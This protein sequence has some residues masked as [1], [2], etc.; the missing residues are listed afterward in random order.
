[1]RCL[2]LST[3]LAFALPLGSS[4]TAADPQS[5]PENLLP[6][7]TATGEIPGWMSFHDKPGTRTGD[8]W[9]LGSDGVL[10]CKGQPLG[11]LY[12]QRD[13]TDFVLELEWRWPPG[14]KPGNGGVLGRLTGPHKVWPKS[15]EFQLNA[16]QA[17]DFWGL[18]G[19]EIAGPIA[20]RKIVQ[21]PKFGRLTHI[22]R[23]LD[24]EKPAGQWNHYHIAVQGDAATL[25]ING[26]LVNLAVGC[27]V[28]PGKI[29]LTAE[30]SEIHF[31]NLRLSIPQ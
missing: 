26:K 13:Y 23:T 29:V 22:K 28:T 18:D 10:V 7:Q 14:A 31:R 17:G 9:K 24:M 16:G 25:A 2:A 30:G 21:H 8:V 15:L 27:H 3:L 19:Y 20:Q 11:Y 6:A 5:K 1:M 12:T 4:T